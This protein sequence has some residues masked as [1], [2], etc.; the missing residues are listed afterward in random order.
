M[1]TNLSFFVEQ[2]KPFYT[3]FY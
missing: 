1:Q 2:K 3:I